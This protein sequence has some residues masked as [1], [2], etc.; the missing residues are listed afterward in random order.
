MAAVAGAVAEEDPGG[1]GR[2]AAELSRAYVNDGGDIALHLTAGRNDSSLA[3]S[4]V[5][6]VRHY[7]VQ[8]R[9]NSLIPSVASRPAAGVDAVS[10]S[11]LPTR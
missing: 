6:T 11:E 7:S 10:P 1:D 5:P 2:T 9:C 3:W 4:S 8:P